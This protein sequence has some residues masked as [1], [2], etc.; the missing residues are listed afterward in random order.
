MKLFR[1]R[2]SQRSGTLPLELQP[3]PVQRYASCHCLDA[4]YQPDEP[5]E[6]RDGEQAACAEWQELVFHTEVQDTASDAWK[7]LEAYIAEIRDKGSDELNPRRGI[8]SEKWEQIVAL[9]DKCR[10]RTSHVR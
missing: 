2:F 9:P 1:P 3:N 6:E 7:S 8:G 4:Q 10:T 5:G